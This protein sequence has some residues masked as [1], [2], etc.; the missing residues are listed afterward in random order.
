MEPAVA[1]KVNDGQITSSPRLDAQRHQRA[2]QGVGAA[3]DA[4]R[5]FRLAIG[6]QVL[7]EFLDVRAE[8]QG[9]GIADFVDRPADFVAEREI[10]FL[11]IEQ[12]HFHGE[13]RVSNS[14]EIGR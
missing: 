1:K 9:L 11:Q 2:K 4:D 5:V 6:G 7:F 3:G 13:G 8:D 12:F 10:L 14:G